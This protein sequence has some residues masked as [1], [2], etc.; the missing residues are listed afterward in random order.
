MK[1]IQPKSLEIG[2]TIGVAALTWKPDAKKV[3]E[4]EAILNSIG[5]EVDVHENMEL[6]DGQMAGTEAQRLQAF[7]E[8]LLDETIDGILFARGGYGSTQLLAD[9]DFD[10]IA[11]T[12]KHIQGYSDLTA[13]LNAIYA[14]TGLV[15]YH[16]PMVGTNNVQ[17]ADER[18]RESFLN[19][20]VHQKS[21]I[22]LKPCTLVNAGKAEGT[23]VGG[24]MS[25]MDHLIGT[26]YFPQDEKLILLLEDVFEKVNELD[27]SC[28]HLQH[29]GIKQR[30]QGVVFGEEADWGD[31][32]MPFGYSIAEILKKH[33]PNVPCVMNASIGH[34]ETILTLPIGAYVRFEANDIKSQLVL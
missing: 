7:N 15:T 24:N 16:G 33:F 27:K 14:K 4:A 3:Y 32:E 28:H 13:L 19:T 8:L 25:L 12:A 17:F 2:G 9:V 21:E 1:K 22:S 11:K 29:A 10:L 20:A 18:T 30:I 34:G 5:F 23:L 31:N 6:S 26:P